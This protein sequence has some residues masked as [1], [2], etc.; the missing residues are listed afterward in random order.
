MWYVIMYKGI[1][2]FWPVIMKLYLV[3]AERLIK[4]KESGRDADLEIEYILW[5]DWGQ[6]GMGGHGVWSEGV[7]GESV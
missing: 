2:A 1:L 7:E 6:V 5:T 4:V 3:D